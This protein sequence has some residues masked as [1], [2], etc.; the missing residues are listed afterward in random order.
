MTAIRKKKAPDFESA[1]QWY[2]IGTLVPWDRN[3]RINDHAVSEVAESIERFGFASPIIARPIDDGKLEIVAGHT[4]HKAALELGL[5]RVPVRIM[6]LDP[7]DAKL[8]ALADNKLSELAEWS[9]DLEEIMRELH[10]DGIDLDG[11]GWSR[12][13]LDLMI[14]PIPEEP[15]GSEDDIP[16]LVDGEPDSKPGQT[17]QLGPH[18]LIVGDSTKKETWERLLGDELA[19][20]VWTDP[21]YGV[22]YESAAGTIQND[23]LKLDD[24]RGL[25]D[26][27]LGLASDHCK[28]GA[29]FYV[30]GPQGNHLSTFLNSLL[31]LGIWRQ[32]LVWLKNTFPLG[33]SDYHYRSESVIYGWKPGAKHPWIGGRA[34]DNILEFK[35]PSHNKQHPTM[36]PVELIE[37]CLSNHFKGGAIVADPFAGSGST[38]IAA[39]RLSFSAR[40]IELDPKYA[41][42]IRRRWTQYAIDHRIDPGP[43]AL[44]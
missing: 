16:D 22:S 11:I 37:H 26:A 15:D 42:V 23:D 5:D 10:Q 19:E 1:A 21:P 4:R 14:A 12:E 29:P 27:S 32:T 34:Q 17:Y 25:L 13:E 6:D 36:K 44:E 30:A 40:L 9:D 35:K 8:L 31:D 7:A 20:I 33:H 24:L 43:G 41:D 28:P 3:P 2:P 18:K 39:Q 38:M